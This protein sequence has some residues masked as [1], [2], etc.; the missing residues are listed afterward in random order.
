MT[1]LRSVATAIAVLLVATPLVAQNS[2]PL[3]DTTV[4]GAPVAPSSIVPS[5][6]IIDRA[7]STAPTSSWT[8]ATSIAAVKDPQR[9]AVR[10]ESGSTPENKVL[11]IVGAS[12][13]IVGGIIGGHSGT[14]IMVG[15]TVVGLV[16]LW[17]YLK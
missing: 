6:P 5:T 9:T 7:P 17:N 15:G 3:S 2:S 8:N 13:L 10:M 4:R 11:M 14:V 12:G 16:G 1:H